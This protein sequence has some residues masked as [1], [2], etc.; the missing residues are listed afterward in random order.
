MADQS[1]SSIL[2]FG[3]S[4][5]EKI[6]AQNNISFMKLFLTQDPIIWDDFITVIW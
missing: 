4:E 5:A 3:A 1:E 6:N 2:K